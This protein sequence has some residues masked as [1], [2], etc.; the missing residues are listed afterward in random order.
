MVC[1]SQ[2]IQFNSI[3]YYLC[4]ESTATR[5]NNNNNTYIIAIYTENQRPEPKWAVEPVKEKTSEIVI[6]PIF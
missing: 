3:L 2:I 6:V 1:I 5:P 4:A